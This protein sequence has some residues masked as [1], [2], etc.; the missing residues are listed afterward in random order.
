MLVR[1]FLGRTRKDAEVPGVQAAGRGR[2]EG[3]PH[4]GRKAA[5]RAIAW[6]EVRRTCWRFFRPKLMKF[7][8]NLP[9]FFWLSV[10]QHLENFNR[11]RCEHFGMILQH[12]DV[13][14]SILFD[15]FTKT[16]EIEL[17]GGAKSGL[18]SNNYFQKHRLRYCR[19]R[20]IHVCF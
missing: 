10:G 5:Q 13:V 4:Q 1:A 2:G 18:A 17:S 8:P 20:A 7:L 6:L 16:S 11:I 9:Y 14:W 15:R 12:V 3:E 19:G